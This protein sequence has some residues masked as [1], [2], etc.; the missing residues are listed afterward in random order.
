MSRSEAKKRI[1]SLGGRIASSVSNK[2]DYVV[3]GE[4][5]GSKAAKAQELGVKVL[6]EDAFQKLIEEA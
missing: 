3:I 4:S 6:D 5:P 1:A 2:T